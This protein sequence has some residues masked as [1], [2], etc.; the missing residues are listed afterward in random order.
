[1]S[2]RRE[3]LPDRRRCVS[4]EFS[5][6]GHRYVASAGFYPCGRLGEI[7]IHGRKAGSTAELHAQDAA[8]LTSM[9]LQH[10]VK[11]EAIAHSIA[12]P[13]ATAIKMAGGRE[14]GK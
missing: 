5:H 7:F 4:F 10:G 8:I 13:I 11:P 2:E 1:M 3:R 12:G 9:L 14:S 6:D